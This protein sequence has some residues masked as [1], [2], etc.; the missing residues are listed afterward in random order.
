MLKQ[1]L[2]SLL[3]KVESKMTNGFRENIFRNI[4]LYPL[5]ILILQLPILLTQHAVYSVIFVSLAVISLIGYFI[6]LKSKVVCQLEY[7]MLF[8]L[9]VTLTIL[10]YIGFFIHIEIYNY[11]FIFLQSV[12]VLTAINVLMMYGGRSKDALK[13][14]TMTKFTTSYDKEELAILDKLIKSETILARYIFS[15]FKEMYKAYIPHL[16]LYIGIDFSNPQP[17]GIGHYRLADNFE[18]V[19]S[20][21]LL[22]FIKHIKDNDLNV[23]DTTKKDFEVF[24]M[25]IY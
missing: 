15:N 22:D 21:S 4:F 25:N 8:F 17:S 2:S 24:M 23:N 18:L 6:S 3:L 9:T 16:D 13:H 20:Y 1:Y 12:G 19:N 10:S 11:M 14:Y 7:S 5:L